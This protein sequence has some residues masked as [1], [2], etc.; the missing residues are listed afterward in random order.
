MTEGPLAVDRDRCIGAGQCVLAMPSVFAQDDDGLVVAD[1][2]G[3]R[4]LPARAAQ[5]V[6]LRCPSGAIGRR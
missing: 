4:T 6:I 3:L 1:L 2:H 5:E